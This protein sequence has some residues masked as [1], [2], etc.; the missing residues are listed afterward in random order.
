M[1]YA[2]ALLSAACFMTVL[3]VM[4]IPAITARVVSTGRE[5]ARVMRATDLGDDAKEQILQRASL[6]LLGAFASITG[7]TAVAIAAAAAPV[8]LLHAGGLVAAGV[9]WSYLASWQGILLTA[10]AMTAVC[11]VKVGS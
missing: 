5:A 8:L 3:R 10:A 7:R 9:V 1:V 11:F 4:A 6:S 2:A